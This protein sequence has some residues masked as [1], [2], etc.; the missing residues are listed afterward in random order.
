MDISTNWKPDADAAASLSAHERSA[1]RA[2]S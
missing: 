2:F 1:G